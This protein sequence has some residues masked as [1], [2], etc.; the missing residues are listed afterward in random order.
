MIRTGRFQAPSSCHFVSCCPPEIALKDDRKL[1]PNSYS[2]EI[3]CTWTKLPVFRPPSCRS[4]RTKAR[5]RPLAVRM[6]L[7]RKQALIC[8]AAVAW[9]FFDQTIPKTVTQQPDADGIRTELLCARCQAH[10]GHLFEGEGF[11]ARNLRHCVNTLSLD[12]VAHA[13]VLDTEE[14]ILGGD[15]FWGVE[16]FLKQRSGVLKTEV[17]YCGGPLK[18]PTYEQVCSGQT[19]HVEAVRVVY[20]PDTLRFTELVQY[21]FENHDPTQTDGQGPDI[22]PQYASVIFYYDD[23]QRETAAALKN[24][25]IQKG[26]PVVTQILP[27]RPFWPAE[28][29]HQDYCRKHGQTPYCHRS[30]RQF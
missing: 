8:A 26:A 23:S 5:N 28:D 29:Y 3:D 6:R 4:C 10:L 17:G 7:Y 12:F 30:V 22:G 15:C 13:Q 24:T 21:F 19:G 11:T 16:Y 1:W 9:P 27:V 20:D 14:A 18:H 2:I 25:L